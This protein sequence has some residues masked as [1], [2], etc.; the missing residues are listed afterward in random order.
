[1]MMVA[2]VRL[3]MLLLLMMMRMVMVLLMVLT[4]SCGS[5]HCFTPRGPVQ[6]PIP[7]VT[8]AVASRPVDGSWRAARSRVEGA[9][10]DREPLMLL[11]RMGVVVRMMVVDMVSR[12]R[13]RI[14]AGPR[15]VTN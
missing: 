8:A 14:S 11:Q 4:R 15:S 5:V 10:G 12:F 1:M 7:D 9:G 6:P 3:L 2:A 13:R